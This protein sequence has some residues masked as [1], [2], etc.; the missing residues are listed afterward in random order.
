[1]SEKSTQQADPKLSNDDHDSE[2]GSS[3]H[4]RPKS[5][6]SSALGSVAAATTKMSEV[7]QSWEMRHLGWRSGG[8]RTFVPFWSLVPSLSLWAAEQTRTPESPSL[9]FPDHRN[10]SQ[11][12]GS[13]KSALPHPKNSTSP[14]TGQVAYCGV[15]CPT[16]RQSNMFLISISSV[17]CPSIHAHLAQ[18]RCERTQMR[19]GLEC[20]Q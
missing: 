7:R 19:Q 5:F 6:R 2:S 18:L 3:S 4:Y 15:A 17:A 10:E 9:V 20:N 12:S 13:M 1:M 11:D 16:Y 14:E 8:T